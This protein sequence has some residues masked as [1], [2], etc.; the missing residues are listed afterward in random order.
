MPRHLRLVMCDVDCGS[1]TPSMVKKVLAWRSAHREAADTLWSNLQAGNEA[2]AKELTRLAQSP[3]PD[4]TRYETLRTIIKSNRSLIR[5]MGQQSGVPME[6]RQQT[7]LLDYCSELEGVVGGVVPG[8]GGFDAVVLLVEDKQDVLAKLKTALEQ[9]RD[10]D[11]ADAPGGG[12]IGKVGI[13][14]VR[15]EMVGVRQEDLGLYSEW[16]SSS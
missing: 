11:D 16:E 13:I 6:P 15:E 3:E 1:E 10:E 4:E 9:Y 12:K 5:E 14:G 2:L 7:R 8:A